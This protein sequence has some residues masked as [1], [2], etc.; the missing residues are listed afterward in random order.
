MGDRRKIQFAVEVIWPA[1]IPTNAG[2]RVEFKLSPHHLL[3]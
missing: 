1:V 3:N 2:V